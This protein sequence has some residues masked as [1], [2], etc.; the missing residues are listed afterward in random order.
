MYHERVPPL[1]AL[2][3]V[4][5]KCIVKALPVAELAPSAASAEGSAAAV[6]AAD[7]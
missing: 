7:D 3:A 4:D 1:A 6:L 5:A 2:D